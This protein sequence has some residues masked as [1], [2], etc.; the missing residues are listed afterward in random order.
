MSSF[1][2]L[3][4]K[5]L[6]TRTYCNPALPLRHLY[7]PTLSLRTIPFAKTLLPL[8]RAQRLL[9]A[10]L[11]WS[12]NAYIQAHPIVVRVDLRVQQAR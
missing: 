11:L 10:R 5:V 4:T 8:H 12:Q 9:S 7:Y 1:E 2:S 6:G 3:L